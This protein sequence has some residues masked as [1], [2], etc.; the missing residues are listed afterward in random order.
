MCQAALVQRAGEAAIGRPSV[1]DQYTGEVR[2]QDRD[3][4][5]K[6]TPGADRIHGGLRCRER[7]QPVQHG[8]DAPAGFIRTDDGLPRI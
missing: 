6:A 2:A 5:V 3:R 7:P 4:I 8:T 1:A